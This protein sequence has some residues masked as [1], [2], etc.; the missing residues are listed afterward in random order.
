MV[1]WDWEEV[2]DYVRRWASRG[3][4]GEVCRWPVARCRSSGKCSPDSRRICS[5]VRNWRSFGCRI[6]SCRRWYVAHRRGW[7]W[8]RTSWRASSFRAGIYNSDGCFSCLRLFRASPWLWCHT[9]IARRRRTRWTFDFLWTA[10]CLEI[11]TRARPMC[12]MERTAS[13]YVCLASG[14]EICQTQVNHCKWR[15]NR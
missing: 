15:A 11:S 5:R 4:G 9:N 12:T 6:N 13:T 14:R 8:C 3:K 7:T 2:K 1:D 10:P